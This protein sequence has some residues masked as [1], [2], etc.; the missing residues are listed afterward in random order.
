MTRPIVIAPSILSSD[1]SRLGEEVAAVDRTGADWIHLDV[2]DGHFVPNITFGPPVVKAIRGASAKVFDCHLMISPCDPYIEA[3]AE[4]GLE[5]A[6]ERAVGLV[7]QPGVEFGSESVHVYDR[8]VAGSLAAT[9]RDLPQFVFEAHSTDYQP[10]SALAALVED[11]FAILKVGPALTFAMREA[12]YGLDAIG[13]VLQ[14]NSA[15][16]E[17]RAA[18]ERLMVETPGHW[19]GHYHGSD[20]QLRRQR[21][22][23][24]SDRIR[25]YW[26]HPAAAA[27][28]DR[29][30]AGFG[31]A[32]IPETLIS[33]YLHWL[34]QDVREGRCRPVAAD[35]VEH[36]IRKVI[37]YYDG[38][39]RCA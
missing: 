23:S 14:A 1:F 3:F 26:P 29:L 21:H 34:Y 31:D 39:A 25:Y 36:S 9:L 4:A 22:F 24:Y 20:A 16:G 27:A 7:V 33:Q 5:A 13:G 37:A 15:G 32:T 28:V 6:F 38:A 17:L 30:M 2:M 10:Q 12:F 35:L 11:G 18:M 8:A 19:R